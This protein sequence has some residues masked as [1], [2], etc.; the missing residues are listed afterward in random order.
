[1]KYVQSHSDS[2]YDYICCVEGKEDEAFYRSVNMPL[3][4]ENKVRFL[5]ADYDANKKNNHDESKQA[6]VVSCEEIYKR[7]PKAFGKCAFIVGHDYFGLDDCKHSINSEVKKFITVLPVYSFENYFMQDENLKRILNSHLNYNDIN[8]FLL[9]YK[10]FIVDIRDYFAL[11]RTIYAQEHMDYEESVEDDDLF[12]FNFREEPFFRVDKFQYERKAMQAIM[13][14]HPHLDGYF[15][16]SKEILSSC[17]D[18][19]KGKVLLRFLID[20]LKQVHG[21]DIN[22]YRGK[23]Y[24]DLVNRLQVDLDVILPSKQ[25]Y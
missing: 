7:H 3:F 5:Y 2:E 24:E 20:Y 21:I 25:L 18:F 9:K 15:E 22:M 13:T 4:T 8:K 14:S 17:T 19:T 16:N 1:M 23:G 11:K 6:V 10:Q 12:F